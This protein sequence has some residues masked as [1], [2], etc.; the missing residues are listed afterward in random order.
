MPQPQ[1]YRRVSEDPSKGWLN[2]QSSKIL[3][4]GLGEP[5]LQKREE[6]WSKK[7]IAEFFNLNRYTVMLFLDNWD[8]LPAKLQRQYR[9]QLKTNDVW[10][11]SKRTQDLFTKVEKKLEE[12]EASDPNLY[13]EY[14]GE[15]RQIL[16]LAAAV[17]ADAMKLDHQKTM[18]RVFLEEIALES[19]ET[20]ERILARLRST[21]ELAALSGGIV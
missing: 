14:I 15:Q 19:P 9:K 12:L 4:H 5:I 21:R 3:R 11:I 7:R 18:M 2:L 8:A 6:G 1:N 17:L 20:R 13:R 16:A 10:D